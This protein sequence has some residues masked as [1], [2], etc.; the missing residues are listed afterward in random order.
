MATPEHLPVPEGPEYYERAANRI[1][2]IMAA[3]AVGGTLVAFALRGWQWGGGFFIGA[4]ISS[5]NYR[6]LRRLVENLSPDR[7]ARPSTVL[8]AFRYLLLGAVAYVIVRFT[9]VSLLAV[10]AGILVLAAA[11]MIEAVIEIVY[12]RE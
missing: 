2:L 11:V 4:A 7:A 5:L 3:I 8:L 6:W 9:S 12:A 10:F 1:A